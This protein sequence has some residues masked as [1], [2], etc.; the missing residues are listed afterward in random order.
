MFENDLNDQV[1]SVLALLQ[2][3]LNPVYVKTGVGR[4]IHFEARIKRTRLSSWPAPHWEGIEDSQAL[5]SG[6]LTPF[7]NHINLS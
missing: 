3:N 7:Y 6:H 2:Q 1:F 4:V 5:E